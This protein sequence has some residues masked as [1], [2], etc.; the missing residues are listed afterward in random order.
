MLKKISLAILIVL[1]LGLRLYKL[2]SPI[3][4]WHSW[5]QVDTASVSRYLDQDLSTL[6]IPRYHDLS[7]IPS[8]LENPN[9]YRMVEF[10]LYN[11]LHVATHR[12]VPSISFD[13][14][15]HLASAI[16]STFS[17]LFLFLLV[18]KLYST[19]IALISAALF[20]VLPFNIYY[21]RTILPEPLMVALYLIGAYFFTLSLTSTGRK[22]VLLLL[23]SSFILSLSLLVKPYALFFYLPL[24]YLAIS[25]LGWKH[26]LPR[27]I[28]LTLLS[29]IPL[30]TW[31]YWITKFPAGI[32]AS[33]WLYNKDGLRFRPAWFRWLFAERISKLIF[34]YFGVIFLAFGWIRP[35]T[36]TA[37]WF[38]HFF[39]ISV[40]AYFAVFAGGNVTHD[41]YQAIT[42]PA[43][44]LLSAI[45]LD[46]LLT[47]FSW[48]RTYP[49][50]LLTLGLT[51]FLSWYQI[52]TY[53]Q[54]NH[55]EIIAAGEYVDKTLPKDARVIAPYMGDTAFLYQ[56]HRAGWPHVTTGIQQMIELGA[57]YYVS[58]NYDQQTND[59]VNNENYTVI[60]KNPAFVVVKLH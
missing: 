48:V 29:I 47:S 4:D 2:D 37:P 59:I 25:T 27:L 30:Y 15:G 60:E 58:V 42:M 28:F 54:I 8:G 40:L 11:L 26:G 55:P 33:D 19:R 39:F 32:P 17:L 56:T 14:S 10:P 35:K 24:L 6:F 16:I 46:Y 49:L 51:L 23:M 52:R 57:D 13:A 34:G 21:S 41:Y 9:G 1:N 5:R 18:E 3:A 50:I 12:L 45:G 22:S 31:R 53:Y 36:G 7:N 44:C 20:A 38:A 43:L